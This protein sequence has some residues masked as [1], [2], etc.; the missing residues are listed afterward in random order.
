MLVASAAD[1]SSAGL[2]RTHL[3]PPWIMSTL[4]DQASGDTV[5]APVLDDMNSQDPAQTARGTICFRTTIDG[6]FQ[7]RGLPCWPHVGGTMRSFDSFPG[8]TIADIRCTISRVF[9]GDFF[10]H[11]A[12]S[13]LRNP[14]FS[15]NLKIGLL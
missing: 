14:S 4:V 11:A 1:D 10:L 3:V 6:E 15:A 12:T 2:T 13:W 8:A 9:D 7:L 5:A